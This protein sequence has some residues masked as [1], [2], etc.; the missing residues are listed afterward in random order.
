MYNKTESKLKVSKL[1]VLI[2]GVLFKKITTL[3]CPEFIPNPMYL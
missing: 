2:R 1:N 3:V